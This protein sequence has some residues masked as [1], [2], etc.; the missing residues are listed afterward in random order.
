MVSVL[1]GM[2]SELLVFRPLRTS[3][4]LAKLVASL[5][6]LLILQATVLLW[7]GSASQPIPSVFTKDIVDVFGKSIPANRFWMAGSSW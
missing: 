7:F 2:L 1:V 6:I 3:S 5:G 4:P